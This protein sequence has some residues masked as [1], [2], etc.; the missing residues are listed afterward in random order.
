[1]ASHS[2]YDSEEGLEV[3]AHPVRRGHVAA[4]Q[5]HEGTAPKGFVLY[6]SHAGQN[7]AYLSPKADQRYS[8]QLIVPGFFNFIGHMYL[9]AKVVM[10]DEAI[11]HHYIERPP[12]YLHRR[13]MV[14]VTLH[15]N[16]FHDSEGDLQCHPENADAQLGKRPHQPARKAHDSSMTTGNGSASTSF[17]EEALSTNGR[18]KIEVSIQ[19]GKTGAKSSIAQNAQELRVDMAN[20]RAASDDG[21]SRF[22]T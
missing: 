10:N 1:M 11:A 3:R 6:Q 21:R 13:P 12:G 7:V 2:M 18:G 16:A 17:G 4:D 22:T 8:I 9:Y 5:Y 20:G 14:E 15:H 19:R